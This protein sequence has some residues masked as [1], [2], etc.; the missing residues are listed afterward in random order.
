MKKRQVG[1]MHGSRGL[2]AALVLAGGTVVPVSLA[3]APS[4]A[5]ASPLPAPCQR[6]G[7]IGETLPLVESGVDPTAAA[8]GDD[9]SGFWSGVN[10]LY[11]TANGAACALGI[12]L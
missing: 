10:G 6:S 12:G 3:L 5:S 4:E 2:L 11:A 7:L 9:L 8:V 1:R